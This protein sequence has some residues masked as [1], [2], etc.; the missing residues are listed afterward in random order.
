MKGDSMLV[1]MQMRGDW[2]CTSLPL[3]EAQQRISRKIS[4]LTVPV[5]WDHVARDVNP[6]AD[7]LA[8]AAI[9]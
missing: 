4:E 1:A 6:R 5:V 9:D 8:N 3:R 2:A 7:D